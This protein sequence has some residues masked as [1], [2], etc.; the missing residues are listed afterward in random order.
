MIIRLT[1][2]QIELLADK[3][4]IGL[5]QE[6]EQDVIADIAR[7]VKK[8]ERYTETAELMAKSMYELG[9]APAA[10]RSA[11]MKHLQA[12]KDYIHAVAENTN[13]YKADVLKLIQETVEEAALTGD[14]LVAEAGAMSYN[15]DMRYWNQAGQELSEPNTLTQIMD[16]ARRQTDGALRNL[17]R[18]TGFRNTPFA[19]TPIENM[20]QKEMDL[21]MLKVATGTF[22]YDQAVNDCIKRLAQ[23]GLR[24]IDYASGRSYQLDTAAR[25]IVRTSVSQMAGKITEANCESTG[26]DHVITSQ[27][28]GARPDHAVWQNK[29]FTYKGKASSEYPDFRTSTGY[30]TAG[31]LKGANCGHDFYPF[32]VGISIHPADLEEP[33][34]VTVNGKEYTY[35]QATQKQ[36]AME[37]NIRA[38]K[39]EIEAQKALGV[40]TP[41][42][43]ENMQRL[44]AKLRQQTAEYNQFSHDVNIRPKQ[45]RLSV[46]SGSSNLN[47]TGVAQN[48]RN[49]IIRSG[50]LNSINDPMAEVFGSAEI[51]HPKEV[52]EFRET[53]RQLNVELIEREREALGYAPGLM[54]GNPGV[55]YVSKGAS[56]GA[57]CHE[58]QHVMDDKEA[59]WS[60]MRILEDQDACY[61]REKRAYNIEI[62]MARE[63]GREDIAKRLEDNLETE[64]KRIYGQLS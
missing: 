40:E 22:S 14:K 36:R 11:V 13:A 52:A 44:R 8:T 43:K 51:S 63:A 39:R 4:I 7:R 19:F 32:W 10:I 58:M 42:Q 34:P 27:H 28:I 26:V 21:A 17:T 56:Y 37:R 50:Q 41:E 55:A 35:Y 62:E 6:L 48:H 47:N 33:E 46:V 45:N 2:E 5:F 12:D 53:L 9:Y 60:G 3:Y 24:S 54:P 29:V 57:W 16:A 49:A 18:T 23:S 25:M 20:Y 64:R 30:G 38:T 1:D 59:G 15:G 61:E 31:G